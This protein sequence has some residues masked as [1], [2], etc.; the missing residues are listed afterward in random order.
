MGLGLN[1]SIVNSVLSAFLLPVQDWLS[2]HPRI[3]WLLAN[4]GWL[5]A[6]LIVMLFLL[7]GLLRVVASL[8]EKLWLELLKLPIRVVYWLWQ[9]SLLLLRRP[10]P[11]QSNL[12]SSSLIRSS[13]HPPDRL[14]EVLDRLEALRREQ[15][16]LMQEM[17]SLLDDGKQ[18]PS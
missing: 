18:K 2:Q 1:G 15:D 17:K 10:A 7:S 12:P 9:G 8:T 11:T 13:D 14:T 5:L 6:A 4:P 3:S 16:E